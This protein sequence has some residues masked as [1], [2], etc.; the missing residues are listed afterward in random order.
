MARL[1]PAYQ[2]RKP[3]ET[4]LYG[5][6]RETLETFLSHARET[7]CAPLPRYVERE[8]RAYLARGDFYAG[9]RVMRAMAFEVAHCAAN[10][11]A[12]PA[13]NPEECSPR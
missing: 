12:T 11:R 10:Q 3:T 1:A 5:V 8:L 2:S 13:H 9:R 7:Y 4:V 6:V